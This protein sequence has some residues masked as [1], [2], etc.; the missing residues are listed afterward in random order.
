MQEHSKNIVNLWQEFSI[1]KENILDNSIASKII[2]ACS[3]SF[4]LLFTGAKV[5][6]SAK[7]LEDIR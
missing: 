4:P 2:G 7:R 5:K 3:F 1:F 6:V